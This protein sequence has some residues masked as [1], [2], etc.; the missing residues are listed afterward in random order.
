MLMYAGSQPFLTKVAPHT[1]TCHCRHDRG[2]AGWAVMRKHTVV[3]VAMDG[4]QLLDLAGPV[5]VLR[6][7]KATLDPAGIM[8][9]GVLI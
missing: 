2:G 9:P 6:A 8:N 4:L 1:A 5:E 3:V 7:A